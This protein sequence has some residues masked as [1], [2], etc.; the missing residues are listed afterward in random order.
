MKKS[1]LLLLSLLLLMGCN[2]GAST[3]VETQFE[4]TDMVGRKLTIDKEKRDRVLCIGAGA[5]R[6]YSYVGDME[7]LCGAEDIDRGVEGANP[8]TSISRP[9]YDVHADLL[10]GLPS[11]GLGGPRNQVAEAE[12]ILTCRPD[13]II[14][15]YEDVTAANTLQES[16]GVPV[17]VVKYGPQSV[18]DEN[19]KKSLTLLG[20]VLGEEEKASSLCK[21]IDDS[22][23]ELHEKTKDIKEE[24]KKS[25]YVGALGNWG[26]QDFY[27]TSANF[28]LFNVSG[29]KNAVNSSVNIQSG[30]IEKEA[31]VKI[32]PEIIILDSA[33]VNKVKEQY[34]SDAETFDNLSAV[35]SGNVYLEMPFNAYYTNLE[36]AL[37][38]SYYIASVA[39]PEV[40][41][42][43]DIVSK[44]EEISEKFLGKKCYKDYIVKAPSSYG[45]FQKIEDL[46]GF[47]TK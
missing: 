25:V 10:K 23:A 6:L 37:M 5:L 18:F 1:N 38:D 2:D 24:D 46:K 3:P 31:L 8:F 39:F 33:G 4:V 20:D 12:K 17:V 16:V 22:K 7:K 30:K 11:C 21:Y 14:S 26:A 29:V 27:S 43:F 13:I 32:D 47:L 19:V 15:E 41:K 35:K 45:G 44:S 9:Y 36:V 40:Y 42:D 28:P 34:L